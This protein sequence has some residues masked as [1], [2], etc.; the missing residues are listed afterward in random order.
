MCLRAGRLK[1]GVSAA[2]PLH[3]PW[4][5]NSSVVLPPIPTEGLTVADVPDLAARVRDQ[6]VAALREISVPVA[7]PNVPSESKPSPIPSD[8]PNEPPRDELSVQATSALPAE[9]EPAQPVESHP[10]IPS[11]SESRASTQASED[12]GSS[13]AQSRRSGSDNGTETEEDDGMVLVGRPK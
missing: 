6:M 4:L 1:S 11:R 3:M 7:S 8:K 13:P 12:T 2:Q 9:P 10:Q 5:K